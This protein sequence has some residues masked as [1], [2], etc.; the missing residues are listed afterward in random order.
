LKHRLIFSDDVYPT[1]QHNYGIYPSFSEKTDIEM[2]VE[3]DSVGITGASIIGGFDL[4]LAD[5]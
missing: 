2:T 3:T 1:F 5:N 4:I